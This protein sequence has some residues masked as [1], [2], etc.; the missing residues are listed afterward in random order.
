MLSKILRK[1]KV[2]YKRNLG[3]CVYIEENFHCD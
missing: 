2:K 1:V 3:C